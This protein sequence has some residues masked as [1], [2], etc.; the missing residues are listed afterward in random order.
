MIQRL[1]QERDDYKLKYENQLA[2]QQKFQQ[3]I[4][5]IF[6]QMLQNGN[7][8]KNEQQFQIKENYSDQQEESSSVSSQIIEDHHPQINYL[9]KKIKIIQSKELDSKEQF[10]PIINEL[11]LQKQQG[12]K[13]KLNIITGKIR[14]TI[15]SGPIFKRNQ[16]AKQK[17]ELN[18]YQEIQ[19]EKKEAIQTP[20]DDINLELSVEQN[21]TNN[22][23]YHLPYSPNQQINESDKITT[24]IAEN[25]LNDTPP[26]M[27][28]NQE[29]KQNETQQKRKR[30]RPIIN[31][32]ICPVCHRRFRDYQALTD[33]LYK[34]HRIKPLQQQ[35]SEQI[36]S[37]NE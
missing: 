31:H 20:I 23:V 32:E 21:Q 4:Q 33:H 3:E 22:D 28:S 2:I 26:K 9:I 1:E 14:S 34:S 29:E 30:G 5:N 25:Q 37:L 35:S 17:Q 19:V 8:D 36:P 27:V 7:M 16:K 12:R 10:E 18:L 13:Q 11:N 6:Q 15:R 24:Q